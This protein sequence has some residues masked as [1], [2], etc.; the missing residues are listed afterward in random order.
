MKDGFMDPG[1]R[2]PLV[3]LAT[4]SHGQPRLEYV[5]CLLPLMDRDAN[6]A[7]GFDISFIDLQ[8]HGPYLDMGRTACV[9]AMWEDRADVLLFVD[10]DI[11]NFTAEHIGTLVNSM[12]VDG[13]LRHHIV[14]GVYV[15]GQQDGS[16]RPMAYRWHLIDPESL[17]AGWN[18]SPIFMD[19]VDAATGLIP[20]DMLGTGFLAIHRNVLDSMARI[21]P[22]PM[23]WFQNEI[24]RGRYCGED[25]A[26][27]DRAREIG[28][29]SY[30]N[31]EVRVSHMKITALHA[32]QPESDQPTDQEN[33]P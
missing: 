12:W 30:L 2:I 13:E 22:A 32:F 26:F 25:L 18:T 29:H 28:Y 33:T 5:Q 17:N 16:L 31:P 6:L 8:R 9:E 24:R 7:A 14:G 15:N 1:S 11:C 23:P 3:R 10:D 4:I 20:V 27:T 21:Y 19:E